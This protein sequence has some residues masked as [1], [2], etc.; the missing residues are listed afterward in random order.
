[1][2]PRDSWIAFAWIAG[3]AG[4]IIVGALLCPRIGIGLFLAIV[5]IAVLL[6]LRWLARAWGY[7]CSECGGLFQLTI[8]GQ[9]TALNMGDERSVRCPHCGKRNWAKVLRKAG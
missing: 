3:V 9:F 8:L 6:L 5:L 1:M 4:S 7:R 2:H